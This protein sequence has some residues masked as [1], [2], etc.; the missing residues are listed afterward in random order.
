MAKR[1]RLELVKSR[2]RDPYAL[3]FGGYWLVDPHLNKRLVG[4]IDGTTLD[5]IEAW[6]KEG[7]KRG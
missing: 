1:Q 5:E 4:G 7:G 3:D 2:R 6:L